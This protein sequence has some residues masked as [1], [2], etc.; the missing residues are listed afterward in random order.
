MIRMKTPSLHAALGTVLSALALLLAFDTS[1]SLA[2][3]GSVSQGGSH[4]PVRDDSAASDG[5]EG[6][7]SLPIV[8][9]PT[10]T[11]AYGELL[12]ER[13]LGPGGQ[14]RPFVTIAGRLDVVTDVVEASRGTGIV[15][16]HPIDELETGEDLQPGDGVI[17]GFHGN[18]EIELGTARLADVD[19][20]LR[21]GM[22]FSGGLASACWN[23]ACTT[24][25]LLDRPTLPL[26]LAALALTGTLN[27]DAVEVM[28]LSQIQTAAWLR[29]ELLDATTMRLVQ[30]LQ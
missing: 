23:G 27:V 21:V 15:T 13:M 10:P 25:L 8:Q 5:E 12:P 1:S 6:I 29:V 26:D 30:T 24:P 14:V 16:I 22:E 28:A 11:T 17:V 4:R 2:Q 7:G 9:A 19:V 18:V 3:M 20:S